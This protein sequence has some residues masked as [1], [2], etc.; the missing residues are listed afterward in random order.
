M[1]QK[2]SKPKKQR[3]P[4]PAVTKGSKMAR[5]IRDKTNQMTPEEEE[6]YFKLGMQ[7]IYGGA[8]ANKPVGV[9]H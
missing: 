8:P 4:Y 7:M 6:E 2:R 5:E 9:G 1:S 3:T